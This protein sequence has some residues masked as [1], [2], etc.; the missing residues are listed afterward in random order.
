MARSAGLSSAKTKLSAPKFSSDAMAFRFRSFGSQLA[1][2][3][4][5]S[6]GRS[7]PSGWFRPASALASSFLES[8][9]R[10]TPMDFSALQ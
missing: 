2:M 3:A 4:T 1:L 6:S 8:T 7:T 9:A 5:K 10:M